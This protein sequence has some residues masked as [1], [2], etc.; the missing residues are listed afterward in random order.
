MRSQVLI[1]DGD[2]GFCTRCVRIAA[3]LP[4]RMRVVPW[5]E[6]DLAAYRTTT[7]RARG[8]VLWVAADGR[9][10]GGAA[11][12]AGVLRSAA[13]PW[14]AL[15][16]ALDLPGVRFLAERA[17]RWT[18]DHRHRLPGTTPACQLPPHERPRGTQSE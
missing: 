13:L 15:G 6:A 9:V 17:Y 4:V 18:A 3:R 11:A 14:R 5:Q 2:C 7:E 10:L 1:Y 16:H 12:V 8:E